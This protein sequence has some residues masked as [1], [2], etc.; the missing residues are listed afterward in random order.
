MP[1]KE[2]KLGTHWWAVYEFERICFKHKSQEFL[3]QCCFKHN[4]LSAEGFIKENFIWWK[5]T[6]AP[7][8]KDQPVVPDEEVVVRENLFE[9]DGPDLFA[10]EHHPQSDGRC[11]QAPRL[12]R[13]RP[14][15]T[16]ANGNQ[17]RHQSHQVLRLPRKTKV[18]V[19][20]RQNTQTAGDNGGKREPSASP[21]TPSATPTTQNEG[22]C[23]QAPRLPRKRPATTA[24]NGNQ[25]RH[26][27]QPS[28]ISA[29][30]ATQS[31][32]RCHQAPRL[33]CKTKAT[34][35]KCH[36]CHANGRGDNGGKRES[37][38]SP[39]PAQRHKCHVCHAK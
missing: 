3:V 38:G 25:A 29:T 35:S 15:T 39:E 6:K 34:V 32:G 31:D 20:K 5:I 9:V 27:S 14:A 26:P 2:A 7:I 21:E 18:T 8:A 28:A 19:T 36:A 4:R 33:P 24:A 1:R 23:H 37:S 11:H 30:S 16:A 10:D 17:A 13:K 22:H 12:P